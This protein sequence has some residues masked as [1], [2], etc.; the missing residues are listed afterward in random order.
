MHFSASSGEPSITK[1]NCLL[2]P[3]FGSVGTLTSLMVHEEASGC[4][5]NTFVSS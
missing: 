5:V 2:W 1:P 3:V 4:C